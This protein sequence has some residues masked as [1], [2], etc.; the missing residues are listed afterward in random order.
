MLALRNVALADLE[1]YIKQQEVSSYNGV[2]L[3]KISNFPDAGLKP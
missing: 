2:L 1:E 3:W